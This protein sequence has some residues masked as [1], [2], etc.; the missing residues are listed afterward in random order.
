MQCDDVLNETF[1]CSALYRN[2]HIV[3]LVHAI[4]IIVLAG[5]TLNQPALAADKVYGWHETP[6]VANAVAGGYV[7]FCARFKND[8][9][10][11]L[12]TATFVGN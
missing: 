11:T 2:I 7:T 6:E 4:I 8:I 3:S 9:R 5:R 10:T 1:L 12:L